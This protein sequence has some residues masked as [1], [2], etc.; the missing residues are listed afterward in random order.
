VKISKNIQ[1]EF[2]R[3][4]KFTALLAI[5]V[6]LLA[7][8]APESE[9]A[10]DSEEP[11]QITGTVEV[12]NALI[13]EVYYF[14]RFV[15]LEDLTGFVQRDYEYEQ[16]LEAQI[17]G[18]V[19]VNDDGEFV[20][21]LNL[22]AE[23]TNP[24]N[25]VDNDS[26][27]D[28]GV[29]VWQIA[30][31]ANYFDDPFLGYNETAGWSANY[32]STKIDS[33]NKNEIIGGA[34]LVWASDDQQEFPS[35]FG[36]DGLLFTE[37]DPVKAIPA[38]Y[39][40]IN[41]DS[42]PFE[43]TKNAQTDLLLYEGE[44]T[45]NDF[46]EMS[47]TDGFEALHNKVSLEYPFTEMKG[48][49]WDA[50]Y[51]KFAPQVEA[52][53]AENDGTA[54][55]LALRNYS[56]SIPDGHIGI[57]GGDIANQ[58]FQ[59]ETDGGFGFAI[60]GLDDGSLIAH[61]VLDDGPA[62]EAGM[63]WGAEI[64]EWNG[65]P[66]NDAI[67]DVVPWSMPF[68]TEETLLIQQY[69]YLLRAPLGTEAE[70]T[71]QNSGDDEPTTATLETVAERETFGATS[72]YAGFDSNR[73]P[74]EYEIL[75][76][77]YGYISLTSLSDD[78]NLIIRLWEWAIERMILNQVP[79]IILD[80]RQNGGGSPLGALFASYFIEERIDFSR[81]YYFS[82]K[83]G[84]FETFGPP[85]YAEPDDELYYDGLLA[86]LVSPAC[87]S[88]CEDVSYSLG[89]LPQTRVIGYYATDG[90][91]G[92]VARGQYQLPGGYSFQ[93]PTGMTLDMDGNVVIEGTG[94]VPDIRV[95]ITVETVKAEHVDGE[96]VVLD[97]AIETLNQPMSAG[98]TPDYSPTVGSV[99]E[100]ESAFE[101]QASWLDEFAHETYEEDEL[102]QSGRTYIYTVPIPASRKLL[103]VYPWCTADKAS[104][105]DNWSKIEL[106]FVLNGEEIPIEEFAKLEG[107]FSGNQCRAYYTVLTDWAPGEHIIET[108]VTFT[109]ALNDGITKDDFPAVSHVYEYH[110]VVE[111]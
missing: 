108:R 87:A 38:G 30:M 102:S 9:P 47:W 43:F 20:Y 73:L 11:V 48:I 8:C 5:L 74:L 51:D 109:D 80:M 23:P 85:I 55:Y 111:R 84:D 7:A 45:V 90:I 41:L 92:E 53:E 91:Y 49:D 36:D 79:G 54:Y 110:V 93:A 21:S 15:M 22:P 96:D 67:A 81:N 88:A 3:I 52:A 104:F 82:E 61:I 42:E 16:P 18:P 97:Y 50:L 100:A 89:E 68:S 86:V 60:V 105:E 32:T 13:I 107:E 33:E 37:D 6:M 75:P 39:S 1:E 70:V 57:S 17:L 25:D 59:E 35:G 56:W 14:E 65:Q 95:P 29:Q 2:M 76:S 24:F 83:S 77:G 66:I 78:I 63:K 71:F 34:L 40:L 94:V 44:L 62:A 46:S 4:F 101:A 72:I 26:E 64:L 10:A 99:S 106:E 28:Q 12:S 69:R 31:S 27:E 19:M 103:W 58:M 98:V